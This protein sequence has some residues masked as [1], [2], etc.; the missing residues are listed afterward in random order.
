ML[1]GALQSHETFAVRFVTIICPSTTS[2]HLFFDFSVHPVSVLPSNKTFQSSAKTGEEIKTI[3]I[4]NLQTVELIRFF[5]I[6][7]S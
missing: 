7:E 3:R 5:M 2:K 1:I 4:I 6:H